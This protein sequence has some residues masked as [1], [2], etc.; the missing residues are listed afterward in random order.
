MSKYHRPT[1]T[2]CFRLAAHALRDFPPCVRDALT[3]SGDG[4]KGE[5]RRDKGMDRVR[6]KRAGTV[7]EFVKTCLILAEISM[8]LAV[9]ILTSLVKKTR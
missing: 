3:V 5:S 8:A 2:D 6:I 1:Q 4:E 7:A 9:T